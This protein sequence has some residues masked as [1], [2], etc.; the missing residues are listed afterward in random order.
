M[1]QTPLKRRSNAAQMPL[2]AH[3][4]PTGKRREKTRQS[5]ANTAQSQRPMAP[6]DAPACCQST[7]GAKAV[8]H[9]VQRAS[10]CS[11]KAAV[12]AVMPFFVCGSQF[13]DGANFVGVTTRGWGPGLP[14]NTIGSRTAPKVHISPALAQIWPGSRVGRLSVSLCPV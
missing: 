13:G 3:L 5:G 11:A 14:P 9:H 8:P 6:Q 2:N 12:V 10:S 7:L 4:D 1:S